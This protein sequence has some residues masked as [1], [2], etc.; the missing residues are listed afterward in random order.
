MRLTRNYA[1][2]AQAFMADPRGRHWGYDLS[3]TSGVRSG[4]LYPML[5]KFLE[6]GWVTDGWED[7]DQAQA[8]GRPPR[9]FYELTDL[10]RAELASTAAAARRRGIGIPL[11]GT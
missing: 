3:R 4:A 8:D 5:R 2:V 11:E 7:P 1:R 10:G 6:Q 9:R